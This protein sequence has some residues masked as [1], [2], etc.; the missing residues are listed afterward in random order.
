M[1]LPKGGKCDF[2]S[3]HS[4]GGSKICHKTFPPQICLKGGSKIWVPESK[5]ICKCSEGTVQEVFRLGAPQAQKSAFSLRK[6]S[7]KPIFSVPAAG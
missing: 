5:I 1:G 6:H 2:L 4:G 7:Q 3:P